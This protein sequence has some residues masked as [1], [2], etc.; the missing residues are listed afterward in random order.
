MRSFLSKLKAWQIIALV[1]FG[2]PFAAGA[3]ILPG[4]WIFA[5]LLFAGVGSFF[6]M[7]SATGTPKV[8][9]AVVFVL[10]VLLM[11]FLCCGSVYY[12][13]YAFFTQ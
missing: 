5:G 3:A 4:G 1:V 11:V 13:V 9:W 10:S 7:K 8:F 6:R 2:I 12:I